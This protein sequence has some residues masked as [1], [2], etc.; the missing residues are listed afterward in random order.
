MVAT[1]I[2]DA[3]AEGRFHAWPDPMAQQI[4]E[5][6]QSFAEKVVEADMQE[7]VA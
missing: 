3:L 7:G 6:Y 5:A 4:G 2:F 1:A